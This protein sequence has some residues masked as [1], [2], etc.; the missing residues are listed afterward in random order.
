MKTVFF[1]HKNTLLFYFYSYCVLRIT[2]FHKN[3]PTTNF[4]YKSTGEKQKH[5]GFVKIYHVGMHKMTSTCK[6]K[7]MSSNR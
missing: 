3:R 5:Q 1:S 7:E 6:L 4:L 2:K